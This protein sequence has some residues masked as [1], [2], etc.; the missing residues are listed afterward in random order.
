MAV[1]SH[2]QSHSHSQTLVVNA[3]LTQWVYPDH[4]LFLSGNSCIPYSVHSKRLTNR[5]ANLPGT[6]P[7]NACAITDSISC[8]GCAGRMACVGRQQQR[9]ARAQGSSRH[10]NVKNLADDRPMALDLQKVEKVGEANARDVVGIDARAGSR[11]HDVDSDDGT[12]GFG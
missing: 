10:V 6:T 5:K 1:Q 8:G 3:S 9:R 11:A 7:M 4:R 2:S 12:L